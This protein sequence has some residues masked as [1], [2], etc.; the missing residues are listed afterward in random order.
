MFKRVQSAERA[1]GG[2]NGDRRGGDRRN[3]GGAGTTLSKIKSQD[4]W[5]VTFKGKTINHNEK[6]MKWCDKHKSKDESVLGSYMDMEHDHNAWLA[7]RKL[8]YSEHRGKRDRDTSTKA[9]K[10]DAITSSAAKKQRGLKLALNQKLAMALVTQHNMSQE[11]ANDIF[12][13]AYY[14]AQE[15]LN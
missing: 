13:T 10:P 6:K 3:G 1:R 4:L 8:R 2:G 15:G 7:A 5:R 9:T 14:E 11:E 12:T